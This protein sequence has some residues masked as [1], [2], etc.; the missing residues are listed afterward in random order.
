MKNIVHSITINTLSVFILS[1][2]VFFS[3]CRKDPEPTLTEP[4]T[5]ADAAFSYAPSAANDNIIEFT[6]ANSTTAFSS[7]TFPG[8]GYFNN[9]S[10]DSLEK[11]IF[12][13]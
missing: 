11:R 13:I 9:F 2:L 12:D 4:P 10:L 5:A 6:A 7:L 3:S 8:N 1:S